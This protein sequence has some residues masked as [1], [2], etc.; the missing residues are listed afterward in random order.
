[1][2]LFNY[3]SKKDMAAHVGQPL[4]Y[5]ETSMF[6]VE[7]IPDGTIT[8]AHRPL[9]DARRIQKM[10][11]SV[12]MGWS[13]NQ[14]KTEQTLAIDP[15]LWEAA[16]LFQIKRMGFTEHR[17]LDS[18]DVPNVQFLAS[19][20]EVARQTPNIAHW[21]PTREVKILLAFIKQYGVHYIPDNLTIR[22]SSPMVDDK[23]LQAFA[24]MPRITTSTVH[25][26]QT[27][28]VGHVCPARTQNNECGPCR[29]CWS[30]AVGNVSYPIH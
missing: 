8:G 3:P 14:I 22:V 2:M 28:P 26:K 11:P 6:G 16:V 1:M 23:P 27:K 30:G 12:N 21:L 18:G 9:V 10:R 24:N 5:T 19:V 4:R 13:K 7:Y 17:W 29:A 15:T 25:N 20:C